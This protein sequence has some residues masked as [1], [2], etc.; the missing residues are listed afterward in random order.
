M[1][2]ISN[3]LSRLCTGFEEE[4]QGES[5]LLLETDLISD[6]LKEQ[7][8]EINLAQ[9]HVIL[10]VWLLQVRQPC[11]IEAANFFIS[12][13]TVKLQGLTYRKSSHWNACYRS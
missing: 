6:S 9:K 5:W 10:Q 12:A 11:T 8:A 3:S 2:R 7:E 4:R 13:S 1:R